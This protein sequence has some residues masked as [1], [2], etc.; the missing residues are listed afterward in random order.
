MALRQIGKKSLTRLKQWFSEIT[1][2]K[3]GI[4]FG[5]ALLI[6]GMGCC[7]RY[8]NLQ[9]N[10]LEE[11]AEEIIE[12]QTGIDFDLTPLSPEKP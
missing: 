9:D 7:S 8:F 6:I 12:H 11:V 5:M 2:V 4:I 3:A 1:F 10:P